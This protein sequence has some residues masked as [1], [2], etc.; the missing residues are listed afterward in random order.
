[1]KPR[2]T[3]NIGRMLLALM[4]LVTVA[5]LL[6]GCQLLAPLAGT[7]PADDPT[8]L[9]TVPIDA[10]N[11]GIPEAMAYAT[12]DGEPLI[13]TRTGA[14]A[15]VPGS[16]ERMA[17]AGSIDMSVESLLQ[18]AA[19]CGI[20]LAG[21]AGRVWGKTKPTQ[22]LTG[23]VRSVQAVRD[24]ARTG[25]LTTEQIDTI[26]KDANAQ[27]AGLERAIAEAKVELKT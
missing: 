2:P 1:M 6:T 17:N 12:P 25:P 11:D 27:A 7:G 22:R 8:G 9:T 19:V 4:T 14:P 20:P 15:E 3:R 24:A 5:W 23:L 13:D 18:I 10:D 21:L 26:L 16:R